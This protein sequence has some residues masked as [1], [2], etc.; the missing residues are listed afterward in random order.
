MKG[1]FLL[2]LVL[3]CRSEAASQVP[4]VIPKPMRVVHGEGFFPIG[5]LAGISVPASDTGLSRLG[6]SLADSL[7]TV[8]GKAFRLSRH[9][10]GRRAANSISLSLNPKVQPDTVLGTE[11]YRLI[12]GRRHVSIRA[13]TEAGIFYGIQTLYQLLPIPGSAEALRPKADWGLPAME[14]IDRPRFAWRGL[15]LDVSRHFFTKDEVKGLIDEMARYKFNVFHWHL[16]D[17][18]GWRIKI[19]SHPG[20]T[21]KGAWN[22]RRVGTYG[23]FPP[24]LPGEPAD[25]GGFYT[26]EDIREVVA[27]ARDRFVDVL[28]E[29]DVPGHS[30]AA[31]VSYPEL[32]C[33]ADAADYKVKS[34]NKILRKV[35]GV[36]TSLVDNNLC[37]ARE[38]TYRFLDSVFTEMVSLFPFGYIHIGGDEVARNFWVGNPEVEAFIASKGLDGVSGLQT[39]FLRRVTGMLASK[40]K[41]AVGWDEVMDHSPP[42]DA[43][44]MAWRGQVA[45][46]RAVSRGHEVVMTP[47]SHA[48]L[49]FM[50]G[51]RVTEPPVRG[52]LRLKKAYEFEPLRDGIDPSL[53]K[54]G[55]GC[56]WTEQVYHGR[57]MQYMFWPRALAVSEC[58]WSP[59]ESREWNGFVRRVEASFPRFD[60]RRVRYA[61]SLYEPLFSVDSDDRD[62]LLVILDTEVE[63][64]DIHYSFDNSHPDAFYPRYRE[65]LTI[66]PFAGVLKVVTSRDGVILGRQIDMPVE[67]LRAR[68]AAQKT[69]GD[70]R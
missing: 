38:E 25:Q 9:G 12:I 46:L 53:V 23:S 1:W 43:V 29:I 70:G 31:V 64:L 24:P 4:L 27:Y 15:M 61:R 20:L 40:G 16:T 41:R 28:P 48:Y 47:D 5:R 37:P 36:W 14:V 39:Y 57:Q 11:G 69:R 26:H 58:L 30:L 63:G 3:L 60:A 54:G 44:V 56:L 32:S 10:V 6:R 59:A 35:D 17:D 34:G 51:D 21:S 13:N 55:Q 50:Q 2:L 33:T 66:P 45:G 67:V 22:V 68:L 49:S 62:S 52:T 7:G 65:P 8:F 18:D 42:G 19:K